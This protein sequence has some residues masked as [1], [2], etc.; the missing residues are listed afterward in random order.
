MKATQCTAIL[1]SFSHS[2]V[3]QTATLKSRVRHQD[4]RR[5]VARCRRPFARAPVDFSP[6]SND[7]GDERGP[8]QIQIE[9][10]AEFAFGRSQPA[11][12]LR[13]SS[14]ERHCGLPGELSRPAR[15]RYSRCRAKTKRFAVDLPIGL[16]AGRRSFRFSFAWGPADRVSPCTIAL[17]LLARFALLFWRQRARLSAQTLFVLLC[18][19]EQFGR[20]AC[21]VRR[22]S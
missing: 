6:I 3:A 22:A 10:Q 21:R 18:R 8:P 9:F 13:K 17:V 5:F 15:S 7:P 19:I 12:Q 2:A 1:I 14:S 16:R 20:S 4:A 11:P